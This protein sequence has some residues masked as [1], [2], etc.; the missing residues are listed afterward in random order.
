LEPQAIRDSR[1]REFLKQL[2]RE[3]VNPKLD[4][5]WAKLFELREK[6][7]D[8]FPNL[9]SPCADVFQLFPV[10]REGT[11]RKEGDLYSKC[12]VSKPRPYWDV[13]MAYYHLFFPELFP[14]IQSVGHAISNYFP[15]YK[16]DPSGVDNFDATLY[17]FLLAHSEGQGKPNRFL[18]H[19]IETV[20]AIQVLNF[21]N[22]LPTQEEKLKL[23]DEII[24]KETEKLKEWEEIWDTEFK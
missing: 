2:L 1:K 3:E 10:Y 11:D 13:T 6:D 14:T 12:L 18:T 15:E 16:V 5:Y 4:Q 22:Q 19:P 9:L 7:P 24:Q 8:H 21:T 23:E 20:I 17:G